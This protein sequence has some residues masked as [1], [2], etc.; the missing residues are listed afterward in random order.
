M[1]NLNSSEN[2]A[3]KI[4]LPLVAGLLV[5]F[6]IFGHLAALP[7]QAWDEARLALNAYEMT[8]NG[9]YIT[10]TYDGKPDMWSTKPPLM[11]WIQALFMKILGVNE[12][13]VRLP[14]ALAAFFT[15][16]SLFSF[17]KKHTRNS[18]MASA[19]VL[20]LI[21]SLGFVSLHG[22]RTGDYDALLTL[23]LWL[24]ITSVYD[25]TISGNQRKIYLF[26]CYLSLAVLTKGVAGLLFLPGVFLLLIHKKKLGA[27]IK[28]KH[29]Y[30][31]FM[32][33]LLSAGGYYLT[34]EFQNPGYLKTVY[35]NELGGRYLEVIEKHKKG[36]YF[37]LENLLQSRFLYWWPLIPVG[38]GIG[39]TLKNNVVKQLVIFSSII[40]VSYLL[41]ISA[42]STKLKWYDLPLYPFLAIMASVCV[43][44]IY[45]W[46]KESKYCNAQ[47]TINI[48]PYAFLFLVMII[49]YSN[50]LKRTYKP[51]LFYKN[52]MLF[53]EVGSYLRDGL[54]GKHDLNHKTLVYEGYTGF[55]KFYH[56]L[57]LEKGV[58]LKVKGVNELTGEE[59]II[60][61]QT[62][63]K[64]ALKNSYVLIPL[65]SV[66]NVTTYKITDIKQKPNQ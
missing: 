61:T 39:L 19:A 65:D 50:I 28:N 43:T 51:D 27:V 14:S 47:L 26:F 54:R 49:P 16:I 1:S 60:A 64:D 25:F 13:A 30:L 52:D 8:L 34:R 37:Y 45:G 44:F 48:L 42:S 15:A 24:S 35:M 23:F 10:T 9:D 63:V 22:T 4:W 7:I 21:T 66:G 36:A 2:R 11:V 12:L 31:A 6:P 29:T 57:L 33:L 41:I 18:V 17:I 53:S 62:E 59:L 38:I 20:I 58:N 55:Y 5:L 40:S 46:I 56:N 3:E 32:I